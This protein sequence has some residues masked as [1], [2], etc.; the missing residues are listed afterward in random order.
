MRRAIEL[1]GKGR[2]KTAPN[3]CVGAVL[4][5]KD[6][7]IA[8]GYHMEYGKAH[9]EVECLAN[10]VKKGIFFQK[11]KNRS[12]SFSNP[13]LQEQVL[14]FQHIEYEKEINMEECSLYVTLEPC[15]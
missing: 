6:T 2:Y 15:N 14:Q 3:P 11:I 1:A 5:H 10:A 8:E 12:L 4:V 9:A 7:I 13:Y